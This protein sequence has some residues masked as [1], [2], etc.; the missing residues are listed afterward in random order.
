MVS[1]L[2]SVL[3]RFREIEIGENKVKF[4]IQSL[5]NEDL[6][7]LMDK[8]KDKKEGEE[9]NPKEG[10]EGIDEIVF[11]FI[12]RND[13]EAT[14]K[15]VSELDFADKILIAN[16]GMEISGM[17]KKIFDFDKAKDETKKKMQEMIS[18]QQSKVQ[19]LKQELIKE[20]VESSE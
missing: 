15:E 5:K 4:R 3:A 10:L 13:P 1:K 8:H 7:K 20:V 12:K 16:T 19:S 9:E 14:M 2:H 18:P 11:A 6:L 17:G